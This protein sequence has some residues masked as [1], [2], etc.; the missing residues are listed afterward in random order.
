VH[1]S[2]VTPVGISSGFESILVNLTP[3]M[4]IHLHTEHQDGFIVLMHCR[5]KNWCL[6]VINR[7]KVSGN[8][9]NACV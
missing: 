8:V 9:Y 6:D 2:N 1:D 7:D 4:M 3:R 5:V